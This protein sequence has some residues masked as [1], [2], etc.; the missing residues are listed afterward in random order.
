MLGPLSVKVNEAGPDDT[1][2]VPGSGCED[3]VADEDDDGEDGL[4]LV[5]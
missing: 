2:A 5:T 3:C 1:G 4:L